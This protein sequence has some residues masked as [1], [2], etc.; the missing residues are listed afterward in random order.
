MREY[1]HMGAYRCPPKYENMPASKEKENP[2]YSLKIIIKEHPDHTGNE[3]TPDIPIGG[4]G[5]DMKKI[6]MAN[7][8]PFVRTC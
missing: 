6:K 1:E 7:T 4:S 2:I 5:Q 8:C 3:P